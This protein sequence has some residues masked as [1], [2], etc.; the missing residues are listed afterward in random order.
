MA[1]GK[2][3]QI[4]GVVSNV[5]DQAFDQP[6]AP[7]LYMPMA[8]VP[9]GLTGAMNRWF[10]TTW[11]VRT[12]APVDLNSA[13][14]GAVK[15]VDPQMPV[16]NIR[17]MSEVMAN[18]I[19]SRRFIMMVMGVFAGLAL[20]LT[21]IGIYGVLSYQVS[22]RTHE[23]G[24]RIALGARPRDV[25]KLVVR[26]G[27]ALAVI[28]VAIGAVGAY[29]LTGLMSSLLYEVSH[30]DATTFITISALLVG[31]ALLASYIPARRATRV[32]PMIALRY[33]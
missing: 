10:L 33:E 25:I 13:L 27:L 18:S 28:G 6:V 20:V 5:N 24:I 26:Q 15:A 11:L 16:A 21:A 9:D 14:R 29:A 32:D 12:S 17:Q 4:V 2:Q 22:Q 19:S 1:N 3:V 31:A 23:I 8:Q 30:R 7:T